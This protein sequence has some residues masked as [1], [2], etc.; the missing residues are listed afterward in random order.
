METD[1]DALFRALADANRRLILDELSEGDGRSLFEICVR[2]IQKHGVAISR[3][4]VSKHLAIL[5]EAKL[6][7]TE[8][9]GRTKLH[10]LNRAPLRDMHRRWFHKHIQGDET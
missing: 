10:S 1:D 4:G 7:S 3:Q 6:I 5:E 9:Q 2:L 8:W